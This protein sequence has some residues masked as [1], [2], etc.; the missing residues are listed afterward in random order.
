MTGRMIGSA[1]GVRRPGLHPRQVSLDR[2][3]RV[4]HCELVSQ[5]GRAR[6]LEKQRDDREQDM[7]EPPGETRR[8]E[9]EEKEA[10]KKV[11]QGE[12]G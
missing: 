4:T 6:G 12:C 9:D 5:R 7:E 10:E 3:E 11:C 2:K 1:E 8:V